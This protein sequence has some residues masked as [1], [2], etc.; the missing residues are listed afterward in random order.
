MGTKEVLGK[1]HGQSGLR[2]AGFGDGTFSSILTDVVIWLF[3]VE[4][5][6]LSRYDY[7]VGLVRWEVVSV[8]ALL[9]AGGQL[10]VGALVVLYQGRYLPG[11]FDEMRAVAVSGVT[12]S[13]VA[14][15]IVLAIHPAGTPRAVPVL[16]AP[17]AL[18]GMAGVRFVKRGISQASSG[19]TAGAE[20]ILIL[21][22]GW[23]G[24]TLA[25][26]MLRDPTSPFLPVG[27]LDDDPI[28]RKLR[29]HGIRVCGRF[30]DLES[31]A[32][33]LDAERVVIAVNAAD[34]VL[35]RGI[36]DSADEVG[37]GCMVLPP[38][39]EQLRRSQLQLSA[40]RDVDVEDMIGRRPVDTDVAAISEYITGRRV[41]V[42]GA[43]GS[44]G[45]E[46]CRQ[47][48]KF[49]PSELVLLDRDESALHAVELSLYGHGLLDSPAIVLADIRDPERVREV[50]IL[51]RPQVVFHAAA[52][53]HLPLLERYPAEALKSNVVGTLNVLR[54]A[55]EVGVEKF[56]NIS[57]DKAANPAS[58]LGN[59]KRLAE[60]LTAWFSTSA[61]AGTYL[62]VRFGNVLGSRGSV[63]HAFAAQIASGGPV[64][65]TDPEVTRFFMTITEAC[66]LVVQAGAIGRSGEALV[67]DMGVAVKIVDVAN[68]MISMSGERTEIV[69]TGLRPGEKL[70]EELMGT[71]EL[72]ERPQHPLIS[73]VCV[74]PLDPALIKDQAWVCATTGSRQLRSV[75]SGEGSVSL[76]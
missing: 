2:P 75:S 11:S 71:G 27:F 12:V 5:A 57:T 43:G 42:T 31:V 59:S 6:A 1:R 20:R 9:L 50:F 30:A 15:A 29:I 66:Q 41:L 55:A 4:L 36:S 24:S 34:S 14:M 58:A 64:T 63:L 38:L 13:A 8:L 51:H 37:V 3:A 26:R 44:I 53:K 22:A 39:S 69:F 18:V 72:G 49:T 68:R 33:R 40:L 48:N 17:I 25:Q 45:S 73:H 23:V 67:L 47:L 76:R 10:V 28:K 35:I 62:S 54:A 19:P 32:R 70:H 16:A 46:L 65:V 52:L 74:P 7:H 21:G 61:D 56:V 60:R